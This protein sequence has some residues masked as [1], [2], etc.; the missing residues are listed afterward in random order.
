M[1]LFPAAPWER[2]CEGGGMDQSTMPNDA[3]SPLSPEE[4]TWS[5]PLLR[6]LVSEQTKKWFSLMLGKRFSEKSSR[7]AMTHQTLQQKQEAA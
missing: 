6:D 5:M 7:R 3:T 1:C 2:S 4:G